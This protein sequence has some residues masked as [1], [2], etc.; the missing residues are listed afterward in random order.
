[1][2]NKFFG[3]SLAAIASMILVF[4]VFTPSSAFGD[5][6]PAMEVEEEWPPR[7]NGFQIPIILGTEG[8]GG[9]LGY[10]FHDFGKDHRRF[11]IYPVFAYDTDYRILAAEYTEPSLI[12]DRDALNFTAFYQKR[13][14]THYFGIGPD[15]RIEDGAYYQREQYLYAL[16]YSA[17]L[18]GDF[19]LSG[20]IGYDRVV[21]RLSNLD[22]RDDFYSGISELDRPLEDVYPGLVNSPEWRDEMNHYWSVSAFFDNREGPTN[23]PVGGGYLI[24][25]VKRVDEANGADWNYWHYKA[26]AALFVPLGDDY[27]I[28]S[29]HARWDRLDGERVPFYKLPSLGQSRFSTGYILDGY[30]MRGVWENLWADRNRAL[31]SGEI[32]HRTR[33]G[34]YPEDLREIEFPFDFNPERFIKHSASF[35]WVDAGQVWPDDEEFEDVRLSYGVGIFFFFDTGVAQQITLGYSDDLQNYMLFSQNWNF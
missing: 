19:G 35:A 5:E 33:A 13:T 12:L 16:S 1:M 3:V 25:S 17:F 2:P 29:G 9:G 30:A 27:N 4:G 11:S 7:E 26:D 34:W 21:P 15:R 14:G 20:E 23:F 24:G 10:V 6:E 28:L 8:I 22:D 18:M 32:R 31:F